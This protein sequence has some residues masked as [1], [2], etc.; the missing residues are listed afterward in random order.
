MANSCYGPW[1]C[2]DIYIKKCICEDTRRNLLK[3]FECHL[4]CGGLKLTCTVHSNLY[5]LTNVGGVQNQTTCHWLVI[6]Q[7]SC[8]CD[9]LPGQ[10][11]SNRMLQHILIVLYS[12]LCA[13]LQLKSQFMYIIKS[14]NHL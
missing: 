13:R 3:L 14:I 7:K 12:N 5:N 1:I 9:L 2:E 6:A 10:K 4:N 11:S 8:D